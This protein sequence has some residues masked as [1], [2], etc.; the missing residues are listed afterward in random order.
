MVTFPPTT[1][2]SFNGSNLPLE[3]VTIFRP[4]GAQIIRKLDID[5][6]VSAARFG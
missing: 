6:K 3:T 5:L 1:E 2:F 4:S